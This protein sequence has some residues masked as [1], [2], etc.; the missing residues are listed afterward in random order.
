MKPLKRAWRSL[1]KWA[2]VRRRQ[3]RHGVIRKEVARQRVQRV[4]V[5]AEELHSRMMTANKQCD[6]ALQELEKPNPSAKKVAVAEQVLKTILADIGRQRDNLVK[7]ARSS[8][9]AG[10]GRGP[11]SAQELAFLE[12]E[13]RRAS[14]ILRQIIELKRQKG[15]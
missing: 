6:A 2:R 4:E 10:S 3:K 1:T 5:T 13:E 9:K 11:F 14:S 15:L 7:A 12:I 8:G